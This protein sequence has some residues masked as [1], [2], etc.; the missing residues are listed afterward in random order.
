MAALEDLVDRLAAHRLVGSAPRS[1]LEWLAAHGQLRRLEAGELVLAQG[2]PMHQLYVVFSGR[3]VVYEERGGAKRKL[4]EWIGGE[5]TGIPPFSRATTPPGPTFAEEPTEALVV[6]REWFRELVHECYELTEIFVHDM[7]DRARH[8]TKSNLH[9]KKMQSLGNLAAGLA[10]ELN[11]PASAVARSASALPSSLTQAVSSARALGAAGLTETQLAALERFCAAYRID[12][13]QRHSAIDKAD[14]EDLI[15]G[16]LSDHGLDD[17]HA[18]P[19]ADS[20][21]SIAQLDQ[22][23]AD[24]G[25]KALDTAVRYVT[26]NYATRMLTS[27]IERA[28]SRISDLVAAVKRF[29]YLDQAGVPK[30]VNVRQDLDDTL[31]MLAAKAKKKPATITLEIDGELPPIQGW[32]GELNQ[33]WANLVDN[34]I[35]AAPSGGHVNVTA[36]HKNDAIVVRIVDNGPGISKEI[37]DFIFDPFFTTKPPGEGTGLGLDIV[38]RILQRHSGQIEVNS[39]PGTTE[40]VVTLPTNARLQPT[41]TPSSVAAGPTGDNE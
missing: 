14:R 24:V 25:P 19:L 6:P 22:L 4:M 29:T 9:D 31:L 38:R 21:I 35:D 36:T 15:A 27:E 39:Q 16:W 18:E 32:G 11:N 34:A 13:T 23:A 2:A 30:P 3:I 5:V 41:E 10:H 1:Q 12:T 33:V 8:F 40:F 26:A 28:S 7:L 17:A 37:R 20:S